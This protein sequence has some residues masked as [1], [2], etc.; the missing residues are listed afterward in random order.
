MHVT[1]ANTFAHFLLDAVPA[2]EYG[3]IV[4]DGPNGYDMAV[5]GTHWIVGGNGRKVACH[6]TGSGDRAT[7]A[8]DATAT[9]G[10]VADFTMAGWFWFDPSSAGSE[11]PIFSSAGR[12]DGGTDSDPVNN[13]LFEWY[14]GT[15]N[16]QTTF[17]E[18]G[19]GTNVQ[20]TQSAGLSVPTGT[21]VHLAVRVTFSGGTTTVEFFQDGVLQDSGSGT[22]ATGGTFAPEM[23]LFD[24]NNSTSSFQG[25]LQS[26]LW[27]GAAL[28]NPAIAT[29]AA[30]VQHSAGGSTL[31]LWQTDE[32][33]D[34]L[35]QSDY[36]Q[37]CRITAGSAS[38]ARSPDVD[39]GTLLHFESLRASA[40]PI[41]TK[42][43]SADTLM[44]GDM[45]IELYVR[46]YDT[47][48][49]EY[50]TFEGSSGSE[51]EA[52]NHLFQATITALQELDFFQETG[53]GTNDEATS[54]PVA[55]PFELYHLAWVRRLD[56]GTW[57]FDAYANGSLVSSQ[58]LAGA[59]SG[60][61]TAKLLIGSE[62]V[63]LT[64]DMGDLRISF[65]ARTPAEILANAED[66]GGVV[67]PETTPPV[68]SNFDPS[69]G[70]QIQR[71]APVGFDVTDDSGAFSRIMVTAWFKD[72][73]IQEVVHDGD[74]FVGY[75]TATS[76]RVPITG[77]FRYSVARFGG[78]TSAPTI[79]VYPIDAVGNQP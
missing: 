31:A 3:T 22:T 27:E 17:W 57:Y 69:P 66:L 34:F 59:P 35:D 73:G 48:E 47:S 71:T 45:T 72:T 50:T 41:A 8:M 25:V 53:A 54:D 52:N 12:Y 19:P 33:P 74:G 70:S 49:D 36:N 2:G 6:V 46:R 42:M 1:D 56:A 20:I 13:T 79:R 60:G 26:F 28:S 76:S 18:T 55:S 75:Y 62:N 78:W 38:L 68:V 58:A 44:S 30:A 23:R 37:H 63:T 5:T 21:W 51:T 64:A 65:V 40:P 32:L 29:A 61:S 39:R 43:A 7:V 9:S 77:G 16:K 10:I 67:E 24:R 11:R 14:I 15:G 4:D